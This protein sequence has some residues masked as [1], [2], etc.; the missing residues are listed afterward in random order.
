MELQDGL[1]CIWDIAFDA[2][3]AEEAGLT[4]DEVA[5]WAGASA[6]A[7]L[8]NIVMIR[9]TQFRTQDFEK[10]LLTCDSGI[11][12]TY[13][14]ADGQNKLFFGVL[15]KIIIINVCGK[16]EVLLDV[17]WYKEAVPCPEV[18]GTWMVKSGGRHPYIAP[19]DS[20]IAAAQIDGQ[21]C[22]APH[23][24][25]AGYKHVFSYLGSS[26]KMSAHFYCPD[27][28][29]LDLAFLKTTISR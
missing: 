6:S 13:L 26:Y 7:S 16:E 12:A 27:G 21:V 20:L 5:V 10:N 14:T 9:N 18:R 29:L 25:N 24:S 3:L 11:S 28:R 22:F 4:H 8:A 1:L 19:G 2:A 17:Q 15:Q 23:P